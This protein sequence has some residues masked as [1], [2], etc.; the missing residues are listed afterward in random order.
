MSNLYVVAYD[1]SAAGRRALDY[2]V[3]CV[4]RAGAELLVAH[5]L[6]WSP[7]SFLTP[8]ELEERHMRR[9]EEME[10]AKTAVIDP[11]VAELEAKGVS[12]RTV[13]RYGNVAQVLCDIAEKEGA[14]QLVV[15]RTGD[16]SLSAR[17]FGSVTIS[18]AQAAPVPCT[19][20]P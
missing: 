15:G 4:G 5:V 14:S 6:E 10:R 9:T 13:I 8:E 12:P 17:V 19:I 18:L 20:V 3:D 1:G 2:A 11:V 16:G 7:Y